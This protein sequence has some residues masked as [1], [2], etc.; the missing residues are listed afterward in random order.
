MPKI[1][2]RNVPL[3]AEDRFLIISIKEAASLCPGAH[4][5]AALGE[6]MTVAKSFLGNLTPLYDL[7]GLPY[8][9][10]DVEAFINEVGANGSHI[11]INP[12]TASALDLNDLKQRG[13]TVLNV[14]GHS[15][16]SRSFDLS[17]L[18]G[19]DDMNLPG[20]AFF[21]LSRSIVDASPVSAQLDWDSVDSPPP[22]VPPTLEALRGTLTLEYLEN[23][24]ESDFSPKTWSNGVR[25]IDFAKSIRTFLPR[26]VD[27]L[28]Q[29]TTA[30]FSDLKAT[31]F[32]LRSALLHAFLRRLH[33]N[34]LMVEFVMSTNGRNI[35]CTP[36][37]GAALHEMSYPHSDDLLVARPAVIAQKTSA[38][39][40]EEISE[41]ERLLNNPSTRERHIQSFLERHSTFLTGLNYANVYP[42]LVLERDDNTH[43]RPDFIL[44]P[45]DDAWCDILDIK[46]PT[47]SLIVGRRDRAMLA[48]GISE[49]AAQLREY[50]AYFEEERYRKF[51]R[52]KYGLKIYRPRLIAIVG[53]DFRGQNDI[54]IRRAMTAY[55]NLKIMTFDEL[56]TH[57][58]SRLLI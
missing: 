28:Q 17:H 5:A 4:E 58:K 42:Q 15:Y 18:V 45:F 6:A 7:R 14:K 10:N 9:Y 55:E 1:S 37:H 46:L 57:A 16:R 22:Y 31:D 2:E 53:R 26:I 30:D 33:R 3:A 51:V 24:I 54:E 56:L 11:L 50:A 20:T 29:L 44:E 40:S 47:Q 25:P 52:E 13:V 39:F 36:Y 19:D 35:S 41:F 12:K 27:S 21:D 8:I 48:A 34:S 38:V 23:L 49:V 43:L 32:Y